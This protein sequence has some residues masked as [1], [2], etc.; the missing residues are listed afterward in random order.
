MLSYFFLKEK[1]F[2]NIQLLYKY[3]WKRHRSQEFRLK[4]D[5]INK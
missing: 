4:K 3:D 1:L 2:E 5:I